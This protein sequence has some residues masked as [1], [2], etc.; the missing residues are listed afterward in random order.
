MYGNRRR[1][2][3]QH[4]GEAPAKRW[5]RGGDSGGGDSG[6]GTGYS[7]YSY[8]RSHD[9]REGRPIGRRTGLYGSRTQ[10]SF[11]PSFYPLPLKRVSIKATVFDLVAR[12][13]LTQVY[14]NPEEYPVEAT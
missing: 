13:E 12:V 1:D 2:Y 6:R 9:R 7:S 8:G 5:E 14:R 4:S 10:R 11:A 3:Q